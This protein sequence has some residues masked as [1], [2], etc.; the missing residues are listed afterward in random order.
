LPLIYIR[1][2]GSVEGTDLLERNGDVYTFVGDIGDEDVWAHGVV[3]ERDNIVIDGASYALRGHGDSATWYYCNGMQERTRPAGIDRFT[4]YPEKITGISI[5]G[6]SNITIKNLQ[7]QSYTDK[8]ISVEKCT[9]II[10]TGNT[11]TKNVKDVEIYNSTQITLASNVIINGG[12]SLI[13]RSNNCI[14]YGNLMNG[15]GIQLG[16]C[17]NSVIFRNQFSNDTSAA[18]E[19]NSGSHSNVILNNNITENACGIFM[20]GGTSNLICENYISNNNRAILL[21]AGSSNL[22]Y[23]NQIIN[24]SVAVEISGAVDNSFYNNNFIHNTKQ[25]DVSNFLNFWDNGSVGNYWSCYNGS[26][27]NWD[28]KGDAPFVIDTNN[29]DNFPLMS[30]VEISSGS[31]DLPLWAYEKLVSLN[32][33]QETTTQSDALPTITVAAVSAALAIAITAGLIVYF[34]KC[35]H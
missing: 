20:M 3:V 15:N 19:I 13:D 22:F 26:D 24:N 27:W 18:V 17:T 8:A 2:D 6:R 32:L 7:I 16:S 4:I 30:P 11:I 5:N 29:Q 9:N 1:S 10:I 28:G 34:K 12:G 25:V 31:A 33:L 14:I 21:V 23:R 35:K